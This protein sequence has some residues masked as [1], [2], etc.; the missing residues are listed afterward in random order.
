MINIIGIQGIPL[1]KPGDNIGSIILESIKDNNLSLEDG[2]IL[3]IA[4]TIISKS[5]G[6]IVDLKKI[7][8]SNKALEIYEQHLKKAKNKEF[9][10]HM[11]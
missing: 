10:I 6:K 2:D 11:A 9:D 4:Q 8:P 5:L 3:V 1:I 7:T